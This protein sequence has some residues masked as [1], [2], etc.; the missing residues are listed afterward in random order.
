MDIDKEKIAKVFGE[1]LR[2]FREKKRIS[3]ENLALEAEM[4]RSFLSEIERGVKQPTI[5]TLI[6]VSKTLGLRP[7]RLIAELEKRID[8]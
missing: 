5:S 1:I 4:A 2:E 8:V 7:N 6:V 3:Q